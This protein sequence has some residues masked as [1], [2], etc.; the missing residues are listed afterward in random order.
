M[1]KKTGGSEV[2][3]KIRLNL[4]TADFM[5][6][7]RWEPVFFVYVNYFFVSLPFSKIMFAFDR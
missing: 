2:A 7:S 4:F 1:Q 6:R 5:A 3:T